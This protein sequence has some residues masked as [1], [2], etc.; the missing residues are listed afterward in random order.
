MRWISVS[1]LLVLS[2]GCNSMTGYINNSAGTAFYKQG[3]LAM[4]RDEFSRA[5]A[6]SPENADYFHNLATVQSKLGEIAEAEQNYRRAL[7]ID[8][9]HQPSYHN[10][11]V[12][13]NSQGR[14]GEADLLLT[15]WA[16]AQPYNQAAQIEV[17][18]Q[19]RE[20]GDTAAAEQALMEAIRINP[21]SALAS[22]HLG[23]LYQDQGQPDRALA[24]YKRS[25]RRRW[26][27]PEV[28]SRIASLKRKHPELSGDPVLAMIGPTAGDPA[29][30]M[31]GG[32]MPM[33]GT[34]ASTSPWTTQYAATP[35]PTAP[36]MAASPIPS[37]GG[38]VSAE[39]IPPQSYVPEPAA[40]PGAD[41]AH[42]DD[43]TA[44]DLPEVEAY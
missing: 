34:F 38:I 3:N 1:S 27:Q 31:A 5:I 13:L 44:S 33:Q 25:L 24:M 40:V 14:H 12:L 10:L 17:A 9:A 15:N 19:K 29:P 11:A 35:I 39:A 4:A 20:M 22:A 18:W 43:E 6:N 21:N 2:C 37:A 8:P 16:Q 41:P 30:V 26:Y 23:Q 7:D 36:R 28:Q 42:G 32:A